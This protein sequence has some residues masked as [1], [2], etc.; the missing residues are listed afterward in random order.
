MSCYTVHLVN[1]QLHFDCVFAFLRFCVFALAALV[2][3]RSTEA[4]LAVH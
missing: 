2:H 4:L 3:T 1:K